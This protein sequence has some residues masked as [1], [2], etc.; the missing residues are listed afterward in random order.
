MMV[1]LTRTGC[2]FE[3][4]LNPILGQNG[5]SYTITAKLELRST[6]QVQTFTTSTPYLVF[7][8]LSY[9]RCSHPAHPE[10]RLLVAP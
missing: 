9:R 3:A 6:G 1:R 4:C 10:Q 7:S 5:A 2:R 8:L